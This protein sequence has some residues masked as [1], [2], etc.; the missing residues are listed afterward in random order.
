MRWWPARLRPGDM[1]R[2]AIGSV[3]HYGIYVS[4]DEVIQFGQPPRG[5]LP[6][7]ES[8]RVCRTTMDVFS[9]GSPVEAAQLSPWEKLR[10][11]SPARVVRTARSRLGEGGYDLLTNNCEHFAMSCAL[12]RAV[13]AQTEGLAGEQKRP[14]RVWYAPLPDRMPFAPIFPPERLRQI[15]ETGDP[16]LKLLRSWDWLVLSEMIRRYYEADVSDLRFECSSSGRWSADGVQFSLSHVKDAVAVAV[17][18]DPVGVDLEISRDRDGET[19]R[20][21]VLACLTDE[22][23]QRAGE[24]ALRDLAAIWTRKE[25]AFKR[26]RLE[27]FEPLAHSSLDRTIRTFLTDDG[28]ALSVACRDPGALTV[29]LYDGQSVHSFKAQEWRF[30]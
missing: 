13:S 5:Q 30:T 22:E 3:W 28:H 24:Y 21:T 8:V 25:C 26:A 11:G 18:G 1:I 2:V 7:A 15:E 16:A 27:T 14:V 12:G 19:V 29:S 10:R 9:A 23:K 20:R 4:D 17:S 6:P